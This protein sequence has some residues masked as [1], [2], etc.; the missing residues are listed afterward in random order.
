MGKNQDFLCFKTDFFALLY[1]EVKQNQVGVVDSDAICKQ[2][3]TNQFS[4]GYSFSQ[5]EASKKQRRKSI[6]QVA[7]ASPGIP[8][9]E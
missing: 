6:F 7:S 3:D 9:K 2:S 4:F 8:N 5:F 1:V